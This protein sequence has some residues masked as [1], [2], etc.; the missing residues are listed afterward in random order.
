M[1]QHQ[2]NWVNGLAGLAVVGVVAFILWPVF[3]DGH[4][5]SV[6]TAC[7]SNLKQTSLATVM[8]SGDYN[9]RL[10]PPAR[11]MDSIFPYIRNETIYRC[12]S[13][14][15]GYFGYGY[16]YA[17]NAEIAGANQAKIPHQDTVVLFFESNDLERSACSTIKTL[18]SP[19]RH[20]GT[21]NIVYLD[22]HGKALK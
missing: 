12:P 19:P 9:D 10:P 18:A 5:T 3:P 15:G 22:G 1:T 14:H 16:G 20:N 21:N 13:M 17:Y 11:W 6:K 7:L 8:Y 4:H 2:L